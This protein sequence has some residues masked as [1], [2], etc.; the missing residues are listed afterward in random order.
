MSFAVTEGTGDEYATAFAH[1][2]R[3]YACVAS[4]NPALQTCEHHKV[5]VFVSLCKIKCLCVR[6]TL[7]DEYMIWHEFRCMVVLDQF[8][9]K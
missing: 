9:D 8:N 6:G 2:A 5:S 3:A 7:C 4:E 1:V